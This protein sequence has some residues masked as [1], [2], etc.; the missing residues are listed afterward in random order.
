MNII[1]ADDRPKWMREEDLIV[2]CQ[3]HCHLFKRCSS[4][5]GCDCKRLGGSE[6]PKIQ[7]HRKGKVK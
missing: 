3:T 5:F 7:T 1:I 2:A 4:R 6:I